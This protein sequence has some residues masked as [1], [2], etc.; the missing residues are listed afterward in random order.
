MLSQKVRKQFYIRALLRNE[1]EKKG[2][3][4]L[5]NHLIKI[6]FFFICLFLA[7]CSAKQPQKI[8]P[9]YESA[10]ESSQPGTAEEDDV[11]Y[12]PQPEVT[13]PSLSPR[14]QASHS[15]MEQARMLLDENKPDESIRS[16]EQ[17][18]SISPGR[19]ENYYYLAEAWY[20][21][22]NLSQAREYNSLAA[23]YL[24]DDSRW[25]DRVEEQSA[26][27]EEMDND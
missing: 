9:P 17:A 16:L 20:I 7:G 11:L 23:I 10:I 5:P 19:G 27:I 13:A 22:G 8:F 21:K 3:V 12:P 26:R 1:T 25:V 24:K 6:L 15:L 4:I 2:T 18:V 14:D